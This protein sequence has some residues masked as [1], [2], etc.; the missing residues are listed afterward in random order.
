MLNDK[1]STLFPK[2]DNSVLEYSWSPDGKYIAILEPRP[3]GKLIII[4]SRS[5]RIVSY[6]RH[7][8]SYKWS[9][10]SRKVLLVSYKST[11]QF[12]V[13]D[14]NSNAVKTITMKYS[15]LTG[16]FLSNTLMLLSMYGKNDTNIL[17]HFGYFE[18]YD[19]IN[20][21]HHS[22]Y[23]SNYPQPSSIIHDPS[24]L[25]SGKYDLNIDGFD[26]FNLFRVKHCSDTCIIQ[27][28]HPIQDGL[29][30]TCFLWN[31]KSH[32]IRSLG[33]A[34]YYGE[35]SDNCIL[36]KSTKWFGPY[37]NLDKVKLSLLWIESLVT[38]RI[39]KIH[40]PYMR[41]S[42]CSWNDS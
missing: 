18:T 15:V 13:F 2:I 21:Y 3:I 39:K 7:I 35:N 36:L 9:P 33:D 38:F 23:F 22:Y 30:Y 24:I 8:Y 4:E 42:G 28:T 11:K 6:F 16:C 40:A 1:P 27:F 26:T 12:Q 31:F 5:K 25:I 41:I 10:D 14:L 34:E 19:L 17:G 37:K 20:G 32:L 29:H